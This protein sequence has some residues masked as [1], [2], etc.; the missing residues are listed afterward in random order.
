MSS[1]VLL[2]AVEFQLFTIIE[3]KGK[4]SARELKEELALQ[5][6]DRHFFDFLDALVSLGFLEREGIL[7]DAYYING[8]DVDT[9]LV[10]GKEGYI[11][12]VLEFANKRS[13]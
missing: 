8:L 12:G 7:Q 1:K 9:Y 2:A 6:S 11:G 4:A 3:R 10:K 13:Y 5:C